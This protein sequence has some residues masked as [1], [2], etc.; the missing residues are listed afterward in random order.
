MPLSPGDCMRRV[1]EALSTGLLINGPGLLDPCE[2]EPHDALIGLTKQQ[3]E[4]LTVSA[5]T[6]LRTIAFRQIYKVRWSLSFLRIFF[7]QFSFWFR[8][9]VWIYYRR[10][11]LRF[12]NGVSAVNADVL[13]PREP[14][15][16]VMLATIFMAYV[17]KIIVVSYFRRRFENR[18]KRC[19]KQQHGNRSNRT[20]HSGWTT[21]CK[22]QLNAISFLLNLAYIVENE[23]FSTLREWWWD[24]S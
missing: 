17:K 1:M 4:D 14:T 8:C 16:K 20:T 5:Q 10:R 7:T 11:N 9:S 15:P 6:F 22:R 12:V 19:R 13:E 2:K 23:S 24:F 21:S 18:E 3:R